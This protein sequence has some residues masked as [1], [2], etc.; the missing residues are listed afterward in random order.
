MG[1][2]AIFLDGISRM[3]R[4]CQVMSRRF[5]EVTWKALKTDSMILMGY[6][7]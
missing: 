7:L 3:Q 5:V 4:E 6:Y 1:S 2:Y